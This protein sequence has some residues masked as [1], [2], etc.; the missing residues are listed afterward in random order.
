MTDRNISEPRIIL[1]AAL[2]QFINVT[3]FMMVMPLGPDFA[4]ALVI[5]M[6]KIGII[7]GSYT[8]A[9]ALFGIIAAFF[10]D[11][12]RRKKA[13]LFCLIGLVSATA[14]GAIVWNETSMIA[15][16]LLAG[17]FGGPLTALGIAL[18]ADTI[19]AQRRGSA[20]GKVMGGFALASVFGVPFGLELAQRFSW[21]APFISTAGLGMMVWLLAIKWLPNYA[22][23]H[24]PTNLRT[25]ASDIGMLLTRPVTLYSFALTSMVMMSG[26]MIIPNISAYLQFNLHVPRDYIGVLYLLGGCTSFFSMR[27][28]GKLVDRWSAVKT[29]WLFTLLFIAVIAVGFVHEPH[30]IPITLLFIGFMVSM[31]GRGVA[32]QTLTSKVP[33]PELRGAFLSLQS[34][35]THIATSLGAGYSAMV[36]TSDDR[37][38]LL[39]MCTLAYTAIGLALIAPILYQKISVSVSDM[40]R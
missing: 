8:F 27:L 10:L 32:G 22:Q 19:P 4:R 33:P 40:H 6:D 36:L 35:I 30:A 38:E 12:F 14:L 13:I 23:K 15:A 31:T 25:M 29:M 9:A 11:R 20:M 21:H 17:A 18:I 37:G 28:A 7:A 34:T 1:I 3:D 39:G 16:R 5:P 24:T 26:F 2:V